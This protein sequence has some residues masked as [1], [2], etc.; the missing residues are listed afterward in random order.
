MPKRNSKPLNDSAPLALKK[1][2]RGRQPVV[3]VCPRAVSLEEAAAIKRAIDGLLTELVRQARDP[4][5]K[6]SL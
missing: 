2:D 4:Q 3:A 1:N 6:E 5:E